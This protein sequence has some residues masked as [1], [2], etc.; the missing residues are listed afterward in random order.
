[1]RVIAEAF[2]ELLEIFVDEGVIGDAEL[3]LVQ[4]S[5]RRQLTVQQQVGDLEKGR[6]LSQLLD[7]IA[8]VLENAL[9][10]RLYT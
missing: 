4:L 6:V 8:A 3:P 1:M 2:D 9:D 10:R 5:L 7:G